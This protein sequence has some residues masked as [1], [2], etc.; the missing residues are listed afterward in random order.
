MVPVKHIIQAVMVSNFRKCF[1]IVLKLM[2]QL[3][4]L[5]LFLHIFGLPAVARYLE[6]KLMVV[7]STEKTDGIPIPAITIT[8]NGGKYGNGWKDKGGAA[9]NAQK[10]GL[11]QTLNKFN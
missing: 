8:V 3:T 4:L 6:K 11:D 10:S 1:H 9:E 7:T 2:L 5:G